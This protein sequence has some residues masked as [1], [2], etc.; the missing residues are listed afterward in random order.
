MVVVEKRHRCQ[1]EE[2]S[3]GEEI[4]RTW[5]WKWAGKPDAIMMTC[6]VMRF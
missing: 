3:A 4:Q 1:V 5:S 2:G 6:P